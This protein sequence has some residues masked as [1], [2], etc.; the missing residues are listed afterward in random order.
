[1][2]AK[3]QTNPQTQTRNRGSIYLVLEGENEGASQA[4]NL[5]V[6]FSNPTPATNLGPE[7]IFSGLICNNLQRF[8]HFEAVP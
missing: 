2:Q 7:T 8:R 5:K 4:H 6:V 1:M 3:K